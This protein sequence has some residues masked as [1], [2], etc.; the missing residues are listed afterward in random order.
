MV[1]Q[2]NQSSIRLRLLDVTVLVI[3]AV[4][5]VPTAFYVWRLTVAAMQEPQIHSVIPSM[6]EQDTARQI[7]V[8]GQNF[9]RPVRVTLGRHLLQEM[10]S[11]SAPCPKLAVSIRSGFAAVFSSRD[12]CVVFKLPSGLVPG[13]YPLQ[14]VNRLGKVD[15]L[16]AA[17][18]VE[19]KPVK[20]G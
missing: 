20:Q 16:E 7:V 19:R 17:V 6:F 15:R 11:V 1:D 13:D 18:R 9:L 4:V 5:M 14:M 8:V 10:L 2:A 12:D 3:V